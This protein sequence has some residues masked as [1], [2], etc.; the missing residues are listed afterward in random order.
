[1][2]IFGK[3]HGSFAFN[4]AMASLGIVPKE[5]FARFVTHTVAC[6][7]ESNLMHNLCAR[8]YAKAK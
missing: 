3:V 2:K 5:L 4:A 6:K 7:Q 8:I 1:M